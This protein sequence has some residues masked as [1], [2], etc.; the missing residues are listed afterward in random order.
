M[1]D[2]NDRADDRCGPVRFIMNDERK[3]SLDHTLTGSQLKDIAGV[4]ATDELFLETRCGD[5]VIANDATVHVRNGDR[6]HTMPSPQYG[7]GRGVTKEHIDE[8]LQVY[9]G[10]LRLHGD[11]SAEL[12]LQKF[13]LPAGYS[14]SE[15]DLLIRLPA[16]YPEAKPDMFWVNPPVTLAGG[17]QP[18]ATSMETIDGQTWQRFSWHLVANAWQPGVSRLRDFVRAVRARLHRAA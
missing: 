6:F 11:G 13:A 17:A 7:D 14:R 8:V 4:P 5:E 18:Q 1:T 12:R 16:L 15:V 9:P 3:E 10:E 2:D